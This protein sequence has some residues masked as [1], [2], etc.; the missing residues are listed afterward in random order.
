MFYY[1]QLRKVSLPYSNTAV[2]SAKFGWNG[3]GV[4]VLGRKPANISEMGKDR[5]KV[6]L[7]M[8]IRKSH[9]RFRFVPKSTTLDDLERPLC[10]LFQNTCVFGADH[11]N[12]NKDIRA[13][14]ISG[15]D[16]VSDNIRFMWIFADV[17]WTVGIKRQWGCRQR[18]FSAVF[19]WLFFQ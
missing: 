18:Q 19:R 2:N 17:P 11:E 5:T 14:P 4:A 12:L 16:V 6:I 1:S 8:T 3:D 7:L 15:K 9:T 13:L 10:T